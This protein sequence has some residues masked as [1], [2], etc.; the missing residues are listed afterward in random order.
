MGPNKINCL[1]SI[2]F[3]IIRWDFILNEIIRYR[4]VSQRAGTLAHVYN[5]KYEKTLLFFTCQK[6]YL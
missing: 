2:R 3:Y 4:E 1:Y 6:F 5:I